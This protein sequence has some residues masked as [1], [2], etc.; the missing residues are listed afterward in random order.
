MYLILSFVF[1]QVPLVEQHLEKELKPFL[2]NSYGVIGLSGSCPLKISF[3]EVVKNHDVIVCTAQ[4]LENA[5]LNA[6]TDEEEVQL[7]GMNF[8]LNFL[9]VQV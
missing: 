1:L 7:S 5:L 2:K 3:T 8:D 6:D 4:I 9:E